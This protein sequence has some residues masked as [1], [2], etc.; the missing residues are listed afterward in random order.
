M[1]KHTGRNWIGN[2]SYDISIDINKKG[3]K[4]PISLFSLSV[5][6]SLMSDQAGTLRISKTGA[7]VVIVHFPTFK[8]AICIWNA[9][10]NFEK[11]FFQERERE[12]NGTAGESD[13][14]WDDFHLCLSNWIKKEEIA[15][16]LVSLI[17]SGRQLFY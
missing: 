12:R 15:C 14:F 8:F 4:S 11:F 2:G 3:I 17:T 5:N 7:H 10:V 1:R 16:F 6:I 13:T 9:Y